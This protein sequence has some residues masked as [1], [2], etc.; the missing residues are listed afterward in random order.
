MADDQHP[1]SAVRDS[2]R[3]WGKKRGGIANRIG[4]L[5]KGFSAIKIIAVCLVILAFILIVGLVDALL[6]D[7]LLVDTPSDGS[8]T[9]SEALFELGIYGI[10]AIVGTITGALLLGAI[11]LLWMWYRD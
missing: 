10:A 5:L 2:R 7:A 11:A 8:P 3:R 4:R 9:D 6:I 1:E